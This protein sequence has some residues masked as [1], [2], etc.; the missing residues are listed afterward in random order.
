MSMTKLTQKR[1]KFDWGDKAEAAKDFIVY[2]DASI[3]DLGTVLMQREKV[4]AYASHQF[5]IH[6]K[7][8]TTH[9]LELGVVLILRQT[10]L[11][12]V[13]QYLHCEIRYHPGKANVVAD[14]L[15]R[16]ERIK[17]LRVEDL[18]GYIGGEVGTPCGWNSMFKWQELVALI[19]SASN[20]CRSL[21]K[22]L[23][24]S[25]DMC[26]A[27]HPQTDEQSEK[28]IQTLEDILCACATPFEALY[29]RKYRSHV[30]WA[31]VGEV[32]LTG[33]EIVQ[34]MTEKIIQIKQR[35][36]AACDRQKSYADLKRKL[37]EYQVGDSV[38]L[39]VS[40]WKGVI[41]FGQ[42]GEC[43][44]NEPLAVPL[45]GIHING[46][47]H[48]VKE[49]L[50]IMDRD[51]K[52]L[53]QSRILIVKSPE[54]APP[55]PDYVSGTEYL[56]YV[57]P[58]N[59][60]ISVKDQ[61]LPADA[62]PTALSP[63]YVADSDPLE[64]DPREDPTDYPIDERDDEEDEEEEEESS[65]DDNDE[66]EDEDEEDEHLAP[67]DFAMLP[68]IDPVPSVEETK[69]FKTDES[70]ATP[71]P[72]QTII[73]VSM[74][75]LRRARI[76]VR[77]HTHP[78]PSIEALIAKILYPPL[79][80]PPPHT[81][82]SYASA[83]LGYR[84][85]MVQLRVASPLLVPS[86]PLLLPFANRRSDILKAEMSP[87]KRVCF[88]APIRRFEVGES[89]TA[90]ATGQT[91]HTLA[92]RV[93][94][95]FIDTLDSS[96]RVSEGRVMTVVGEVNERVTDFAT[97]QRQD[98][99]E[100][101]VYD[102]DARDDRALLRAQISLLMRESTTLEASIRTLEAQVRTLQTQH[103][104]MEWQRQDVGD[105]VTSAFRR[106]HA[107]RLET[108]HA[109]MIWRTPTIKMALK[110]T[111]IPMTDAAIKQ[112][113][114]QI[115]AD[116]LAEYEATKN[117]GNGDDS[118]D[119]GSDRRT[120]RATRDNYTV[121]CQIKF[122]TCTLLGNA[123]TWWNSHVKT[124]GHDATYGM[125]W[126]T[127]KKIMTDMYYPRS[128]IKKMFP[129]ESNEV[130]RYVGGLPDMIQGN[131]MASKPKTMQDA[132]EFTTDLMDQNIRT[133][134]ERQA[135][136]KKK[137]DDNSRNNHTQQQ[138]H[139]R[140]NVARASHCWA[141][142]NQKVVTCFECGVQGHYTKDYP[143]LKNNNRG[144][145]AGNIGATAKAY[146]VGN[147]RKNPDSNVVTGTFL[148]NNRYASILFDTGADRSFVSTAFSSL[149]D[150]VPSVLDHDYDVELT[151][152]K[153]IRVNTIIWGFTLNFLNHP[154]NIDLMPVKLGSF[155]VIIGMDWLSKYHAVIV[156]DEKIV[157]V[158]FGNEILIVR[159]G[160]SNNKSLTTTASDAMSKAEDKSEEKRLK[161]VLI[162]RDFPK[163]FPKDLLCILPTRQVEFQIDLIPGVAPVARVPYRLA[164]SEMKELS[165]QLQD[166]SDKGFIR[167]SSSPWGAPVLFFKKKD[168]SFRMCID[169]RELNKLTVKNRYPLL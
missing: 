113:I 5:K 105:L 110:K 150:I 76:S 146:A 163:V 7:N 101:Y 142:A 159:G 32:Q 61:P 48:F 20:F 38:M 13:A 24:T 78:S 93:D 99:H 95:G 115:V 23:G 9:D 127:L 29:G 169:Y 10:S 65:E 43:H 45:D 154:F 4:I 33:P 71:P 26:T 8:Y 157:R 91:G 92:R 116:A 46:K 37:M 73:L 155:D 16:K 117:S 167:P 131:V 49:P 1:V 25:L 63:G 112:L 102:E 27:Y 123:L 94:Y 44:A 120:E 126:K 165:D 28:T 89:S 41:Q 104:R 35:I 18:E 129:E 130:E 74:T 107:W 100:L 139:K 15:S 164:L 62:L 22:D 88:T 14:A 75:R 124:V 30:C 136:N 85:A 156:C 145:S 153:M 68:A 148:L 17:P 132:I 36:Q 52:R 66:E 122:A 54:Q 147:A 128:E 162:V 11:V 79:L 111:T 2:C 121:A 51:I 42:M 67:A 135:E 47:L 144:N 31:E 21:Q 160:G 168:G 82:P 70:V 86:P 109:Q 53:K 81:S 6:E 138:P 119:S 40:P 34:E 80:L 39:K 118:H 12:R 69:P 141:C 151:D 125:T 149:I 72:P 77:P 60:E 84:A 98:T 96:I 133:F 106:I 114:A 50:V 87:Q 108:E 19:W 137:L 140:Q 134:A 59:D 56:K 143:K 152:K 3:K 55:S 58:S 161:D 90:T 166:L 103:D 57:A 64:E 158:P 97:T 83:P